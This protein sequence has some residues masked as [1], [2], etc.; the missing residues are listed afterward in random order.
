MSGRGGYLAAK[1]GWAVLTIFVVV[2]FNFLLFRVLPGD[3]AKAG[4]RDPASTRAAQAALAERFG[5]DKPVFLNLEDGEPVRLAV[6]RLPG[7]ARPG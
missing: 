5:L 2:T 4:V 3:P 6:L 1:V 7:C